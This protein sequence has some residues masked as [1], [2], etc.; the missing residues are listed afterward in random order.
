[1]YQMFFVVPNE[2]LFQSDFGWILDHESY[3]VNYGLS[4]KSQN[5]KFCLYK[6]KRFPSIM[7]I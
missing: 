2:E 4:P 1:M 7:N 3:I 6:E 5:Q